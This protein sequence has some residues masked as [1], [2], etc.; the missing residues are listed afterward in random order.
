LPPKILPGD[1]AA[2]QLLRYLKLL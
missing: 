2:S 1:A